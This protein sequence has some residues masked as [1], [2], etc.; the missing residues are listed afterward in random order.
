MTLQG[1]GHAF[2]ALS[3]Q[4]VAWP[5]AR[6]ICVVG[7]SV[8]PVTSLA[9]L[10][11]AL[12]LCSWPGLLVASL[13]SARPGDPMAVGSRDVREDRWERPSF[14]LRRSSCFSSAPSG[15]WV[16]PPLWGPQSQAGGV[17]VSG[18]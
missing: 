14:P 11:K 13:C 9:Q 5:S 4:T 10:F 2:G 1:L 18:A 8:R 15:Y 7:T 6:L 16:L 3:S 17:E 12:C